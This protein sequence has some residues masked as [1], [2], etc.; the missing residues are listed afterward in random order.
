M[1]PDAADCMVSC[2]M[3]TLAVPE[4]LSCLRHSIDD[5]CRQ[6]HRNKEMVIV[7]DSGTSETKCAIV[8][9]IR[10]LQRNDIRI[11]DPGRK[12]P[13][14]ALRRV[15]RENARGAVHCQWD[16][17]DLNHPERLE[18]QLAYLLNADCEAV[19]LQQ[20][21]QLFPRTRTLYCTN[22]CR[23]PSR[24]L[25]GTLMCRRSAPI[26]YPET[27]PESQLSEDTAVVLQLLERDACRFVADAPHLY[28]YV[29]HGRNS[30]GEDY[31]RLQIAKLAIS[32]ALLCR[33]EARLREGL[34]P[35]AFG[36]E[37]ITVEGYNGVAFTL[38][39]MT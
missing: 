20:V 31:Y 1:M 13:L 26:R 39:T 22:W 16:D 27:G 5:Y 35:F 25:P 33:R 2:L 32:R 9:H 30:R 11:I 10:S 21:M 7:V 12:L 18:Q 14:G 38:S 17:D 24:S 4:R 37:P 34:R 23:A 15:A 36:P 8:E 6:T 3:V 28:V 19:C 29:C